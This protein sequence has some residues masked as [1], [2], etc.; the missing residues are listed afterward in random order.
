MTVEDKVTASGV[1]SMQYTRCVNCG[2][3]LQT[4]PSEKSIYCSVNCMEKFRICPICGNYYLSESD[5][6]SDS[7][8]CSFLFSLNK[9][10][11]P[12]IKETFFNT[13]ITGDPHINNELVSEKLSNVLKLPLI[14]SEKLR[15][16][17]NL[18]ADTVNEKINIY[19][20]Q[21]KKS[22]FF[23]FLLDSY[24]PDL[25]KDLIS[26]IIFTRIIIIE[27]KAEE[28]ADSLQQ[29]CT[30][31]GNINSF[32]E[33]DSD[34]KTTCIICGNRFFRHDK[35]SSS[36]LHRNKSFRE[37]RE[38][39]LA[40]LPERCVSMIYSNPK[41]TVNEIVNIFVYS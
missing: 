28:S 18:S 22:G 40:S 39:L 3:F 36:M 19:S 31:C 23:I 11:K 12:F 13:L 2:R 20:N 17:K 7:L 30:E 34:G 15:L 8:K 26:K 41:N 29:L 6:N 27:S 14:I 38:L 21:E 9:K 35:N 5:H 4:E 37:C 1:I 33:P 32:S 24:D 10:R 25:L 16:E